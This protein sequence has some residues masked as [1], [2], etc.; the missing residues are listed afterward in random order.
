VTGT[1]TLTLNDNGKAT[2]SGISIDGKSLTFTYTVASA[3]TDVVSLQVSSI[4][5]PNGA[6]IRD[7]GGN[8]LNLSL[9]AVPTYSGPAVDQD[10]VAEAPSLTVPSSLSVSPGGS[11]PMGITA[12]PVDSD[13]TVSITIQ[14][15][16]SYE[17]ITAG[18]GETVT[19]KKAGN[20]TTYTITST[21]PGA[22]I[23]DLTLASTYNKNKVVTNTFTVTASDTTSGE[24]ATSAS[25]TV[26]VTDPP[27]LTANATN[28]APPSSPPSLDQV[29][30]LFNQFIAGGSP[31]Q[32]GAPITNAPSQIVTN[33]EQ[34]LAQPH[35]G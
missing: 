17:K 7:G 1:P 8:N 15:V 24:T 30:A 27:I 28:G 3:D 11:I 10:K 31:D 13:D 29:V 18:P 6:T 23:I 35:H 26:K 4:N 9:S 20:T 19:T 2:Y 34:F 5:L 22:A 32:Y 25:K 16:P 14:G 21:T 12:T 33:Q